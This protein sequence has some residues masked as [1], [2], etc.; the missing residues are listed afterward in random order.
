MDGIYAIYR[1]VYCIHT[2]QEDKTGHE[3]EKKRNNGQESKIFQSFVLSSPHSST[4][5]LIFL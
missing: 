2:R 4:I 3:A 1:V 5:L